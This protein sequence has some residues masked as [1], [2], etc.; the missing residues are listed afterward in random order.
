[1]SMDDVPM[2]FGVVGSAP[3]LVAHLRSEAGLFG[4]A[5]EPA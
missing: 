5:I 1:M 3:A 4:L 2:W